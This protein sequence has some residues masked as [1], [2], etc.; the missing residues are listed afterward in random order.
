MLFELDAE[1]LSEKIR[2]A[3]QEYRKLE[4]ALKDLESGKD[5][6]EQERNKAKQRAD[7]DYANTSVRT[8]REVEDAERAMTCLLYTSSV[9]SPDAG[10]KHGPGKG[11][12]RIFEEEFQEAGF[13]F[14]EGAGRLSAGEKQADRVKRNVP[15]V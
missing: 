4:L 3:E 2:Q 14:G 7:E 8:G 13:L 6:T 5:L 1:D 10:E 9:G 12:P 11:L 15:N